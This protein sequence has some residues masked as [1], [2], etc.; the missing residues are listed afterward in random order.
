MAKH[1]NTKTTAINGINQIE[2][3]LSKISF[4][5]G[6]AE[7]TSI[8]IFLVTDLL[9]NN[10]YKKIVDWKC[11]M[12]T[13]LDVLSDEDKSIIVSNK[14]KNEH[15]T[16]LAEV[17]DN[18]LKELPTTYQ[19]LISIPS[20][21]KVFQSVINKNIKLLV[22][23]DKSISKYTIQ[24]SHEKGTLSE[25]AERMKIYHGMLPPE[26]QIGDSFI[27]ITAKGYVTKVGDFIVHGY[28]PLYVF[29]TFIALHTVYGNFDTINKGLSDTRR[30]SG[31]YIYSKD[32]RFIK[33]INQESDLKITQKIEYNSNNTDSFN[34]INGVFSHL[35][36]EA[37][38]NVLKLQTQIKN[39]LFWFFE[40]LN[41]DNHNLKTVFYSSAFDAFFDQKDN[42]QNK[43][44]K[45]VIEISETVGQEEL[46]R[47][48][49]E[50]HYQFRNSII[51]GERQ[52]YTNL[53]DDKTTRENNIARN[54]IAIYTYYTKYIGAKI[55]KYINSMQK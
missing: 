34:L 38:R 3:I 41:T 20:I 45:I 48:H 35:F 26:F 43:I 36:K 8:D 16:R 22:L 15:Q 23:E 51:H 5:D 30:L 28:D 44:E 50:D 6:Y 46:A 14:I 17:I 33:T 40:A 47:R 32:N 42:R 1:N 19:F 25:L 11:V 9:K 2:K 4:R 13:I 10:P 24:S 54:D 52:I 39:S 27:V 21:D 18:K 31:F 49:L 12:Y 7:T 53:F 29:K 37:P 55:E